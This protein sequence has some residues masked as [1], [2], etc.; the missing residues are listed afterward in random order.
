MTG[1]L[2]VNLGTPD[3]PEA[4]AV[5]RYLRQ[6]LSDPRV[7]D[8]H[9]I[10]RALL[11]YLFILPFRPSKSAAAYKL[12]WDR[13]GSPLLSHSQDLTAAVQ[14]NLGSTWRVILGMRYGS[15]SIAA[16]MQKLRE[17]RVDRIVVL[18]LYPQY[19]S[20]STGSS[21]EEIFRVAAKLWV[22]PNLSF[23]E[24]FYDDPGFL[25]AFAAV[26]RPVLLQ[27]APDHVL[28]SFHGLPE[29]HMRK[30]DDT[31]RHCLASADCCAR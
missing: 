7:L 3:A 23:V 22:T 30:A 18:P 12:V 4:P 19:S 14:K 21:F 11:L 24:P 31:V 20:A 27:S 2:L 5:R 1:L 13:R 10:G 9:P 17:E 16:A 6:F 8:I 28:F 25:D 15:P 26:V 29:R